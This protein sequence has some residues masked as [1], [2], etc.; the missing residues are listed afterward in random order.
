L[1]DA[2]R[3]LLPK[4]FDVQPKRGFAMPFESWLSGPL[5]DVLLE[6]LSNE[7]VRNRGWFNVSET[8]GIR[9]D[10]LTGR[11]PWPKPWLLMMTELWA[12]NVFDNSSN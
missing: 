11:I 4:D 5:K 6:T 10:F 2:G 12:R 8:A 7:S 1:I 9:D 3:N